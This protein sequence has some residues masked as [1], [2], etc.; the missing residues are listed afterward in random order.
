MRHIVIVSISSFCGV[1]GDPRPLH[2]GIKVG[3]MADA[4]VIMVTCTVAHTHG[5]TCKVPGEYLEVCHIYL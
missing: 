2:A 3:G 4:F 5:I 1:A